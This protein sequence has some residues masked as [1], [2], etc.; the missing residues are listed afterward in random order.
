MLFFPPTWRV[1]SDIDLQP[2]QPTYCKW[3]SRETC[4]NTKVL[5]SKQTSANH[6]THHKLRKLDKLKLNLQITGY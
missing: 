1:S 5:N 2:K 4:D 3:W 6:K